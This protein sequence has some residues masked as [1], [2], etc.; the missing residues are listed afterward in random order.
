MIRGNLSWLPSKAVEAEVDKIL[1]T[2]VE[3]ESTRATTRKPQV[4]IVVQILKSKVNTNRLRTVHNSDVSSRFSVCIMYA[5]FIDFF[6]ACSLSLST[7]FFLNQQE[8]SRKLRLRE[9]HR[10]QHY[11]GE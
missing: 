10:N 2:F 4:I 3:S 1:S 6:K 7:I 11:L 5:I 9:V 8:I